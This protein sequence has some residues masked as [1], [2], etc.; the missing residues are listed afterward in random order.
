MEAKIE[1]KT[2]TVP[3]AAKVLGI[4]LSVAYEAARTGELPT[5][6]VG[7]R[8]LVPLVAL[9]RKLQGAAR[10]FTAIAARADSS[11][12]Q[13]T[14]EKSRPGGNPKRLDNLGDN[15]C[16]PTLTIFRTNATKNDNVRSL[17]FMRPAHVLFSRRCST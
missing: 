17:I 15:L 5:I 8:I 6:K 9:E 12:W 11:A 10:E 2:M 3:E 13:S 7:K 16:N 14:K 1:R 4:G